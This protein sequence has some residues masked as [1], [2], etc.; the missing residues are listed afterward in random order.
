MKKIQYS[1]NLQKNPVRPNEPKKAY[2]NLQLTGI[3]GTRELANHIIEHGSTYSRGTIEGVLSDLGVHLR[4]FI[5]QGYKIMLGTVCALTPEIRSTGAESM[6]DFS[7]TN[8]EDFYVRFT[9]LSDLLELRSAADFEQTSTRA[10]QKA[11]LKAQKQG[12][13][14]ADWTPEEEEEEEGEGA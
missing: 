4:E 8:I 3:V 2:A 13:S 12:L 1:I 7:E 5:L 9:P 14:T 10:A 6:E 11:T